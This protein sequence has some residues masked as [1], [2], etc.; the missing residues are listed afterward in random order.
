MYFLVPDFITVGK[1][2]A[3]EWEIKTEI[4]E[5]IK[6][7]AVDLKIVIGLYNAVKPACDEI[8]ND[9][10]LDKD[11]KKRLGWTDTLDT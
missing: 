11:Y 2:E 10:G 4:I 7:P 8:I 5:T 6:Y 3:T 9:A 1:N